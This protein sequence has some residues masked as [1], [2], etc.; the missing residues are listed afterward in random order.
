MTPPVTHV[1]FAPLRKVKVGE[2]TIRLS[3]IDEDGSARGEF[4]GLPPDQRYRWEYNATSRTV[5]VDAHP[6]GNVKDFKYGYPDPSLR[7]P[8]LDLVRN[9]KTGPAS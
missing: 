8:L 4:S 3:S 1:N 6:S 5:F 7:E 2:W 9:F